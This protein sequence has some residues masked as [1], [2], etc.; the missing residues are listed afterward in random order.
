MKHVTK[1]LKETA[2]ISRGT[3]PKYEFAKL[4]I[5]LGITFVLGYAIL[6][7]VADTIAEQ[8]P[9]KLEARLF[10]DI[11]ESA[12]RKGKLAAKF[13]SAE[14]LFIRLVQA[15]SLRPLPYKLLYVDIKEPNAFALPGGAVG[16]TRG[17]LELVEHEEGLAMVLGHELGHQQKRHVLR[18]IGRSLI[19]AVIQ[20]YFLEETSAIASGFA[21]QTMAAAH[22]RTQEYEA[23]Q[24]GFK[25]AVEV[26]GPSDL[27]LEF[28]EKIHEH[29][30][31]GE[32]RWSLLLRS[33]PFTLDR[34]KRLKAEGL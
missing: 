20:S 25:L 22:S 23:D 4:V 34:I 13:R 11:V 19:W 7:V 21:V 3:P 10:A 28:F 31:D 2:D 6:G 1:S 5:L 9:E 26:L 12:P 30:E 29:Y 15:G 27:Y 14:N 18:T 16:V 17:L 8:I 32:S 24:I 33:H